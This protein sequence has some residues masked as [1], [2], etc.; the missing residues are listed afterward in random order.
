MV[1]VVSSVA[2]FAILYFAM[3]RLS[4]SNEEFFGAAVPVS[5]AGGMIV[6]VLARQLFKSLKRPSE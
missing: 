5:I 4:S 3:G 1:I 6:A 2:V